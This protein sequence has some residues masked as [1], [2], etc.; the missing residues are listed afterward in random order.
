MNQVYLITRRLCF[1]FLVVGLSY[2]VAA[3]NI[4]VSGKVTSAEDGSTV[5]GANVLQ[6]GT[7]NGVITDVDG[8]YTISVPG[9]ATL[10]F[11]FIGYESQEVAVNGRSS[12]SI[13][14]AT[15]VQQLSEVVVV[16]YGTQEKKEITSSVASID[17]KDFNQGNISDPAQLLQGKVSG[18]S[19]V[20]AG[21]DPNGSFNIRLRG[22]STFGS[23]S[24]PLIIIDG[25]IGAS[26]IKKI[27]NRKS[28]PANG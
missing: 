2:P 19:V 25:V 5:P 28:R 14:L 1:L 6:K 8:N 22:L 27:K 17:A 18:L 23:N 10:V 20:R 4:T 9:D 12:I 15:D 24:Q 21:G 3:Q 13:A 16:G 11:S 7:S 26:L